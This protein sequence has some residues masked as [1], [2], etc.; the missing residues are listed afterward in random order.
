[1]K[2]LKNWIYQH[3]KEVIL[4]LVLLFLAFLALISPFLYHNVYWQSL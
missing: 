1:M 4:G 3:K 2:N